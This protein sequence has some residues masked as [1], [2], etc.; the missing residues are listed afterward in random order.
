MTDPTSMT[1][2]EQLQ[3]HRRFDTDLN[4]TTRPPASEVVT[5]HSVSMTEMYASR[6]VDKLIS[7]L[8]SLDWR[9][10]TAPT[11]RVSEALKGDLFSSGRFWIHDTS[12]PRPQVNLGNAYALM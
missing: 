11:D 7:A 6:D 8:K 10:G 3:H 5:L 1:F 12:S 4:T 2:E 9:D